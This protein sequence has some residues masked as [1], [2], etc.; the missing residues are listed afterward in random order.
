MICPTCNA[1]NR[2]DAKFCKSCGQPFHSQP[3]PTSEVA[4]S[5]HFPIAPTSTRE[6]D[7]SSNVQQKNEEQKPEYTLSEESDDL[8]LEPTLILSPE[9]MIAYHNRR[10]QQQLERN[11]TYFSGAM[12]ADAPK[13]EATPDQ[14]A[15][16]MDNVDISSVLHLPTTSEQSLDSGGT[17]DI[18]DVPTVADI[19]AGYNFEEIPSPP[20]Q[21]ESSATSE[22]SITS[23]ERVDAEIDEIDEVNKAGETEAAEITSEEEKSETMQEP[24]DQHETTASTNGFPILSIGEQILDRYEITQVLHESAQEHVYQVIDH[25]GYQHCWNCGSEQNAEGDEFCINCGAS[26]LNVPYIMHEYGAGEGAPTDAPPD[27]HVLQGNIVNTFI[28]QG[29]TYMI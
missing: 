21:D 14:F 22:E 5:D 20:P 25:Q 23:G 10:W 12:E 19:P 29:R 16:Q 3:T 11:G 24:S 1:P 28:E 15:A 9:K 2:D 18:A 8:S 7:A 13:N 26:M 4:L 27:S 17:V 6:D